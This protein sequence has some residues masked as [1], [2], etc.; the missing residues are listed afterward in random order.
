MIQNYVHLE[1]KLHQY[2][3]IDHTKQYTS[4]SKVLDSI[5]LKEDWNS[6][7]GK[8]AGYG[9]F[10]GMSKLDVLKLWDDNKNKSLSH[11]T[12]IHE[13]LERY[14]KEFKILPQ[15]NHLEEMIKG[16][17]EGYK[18]YYRSYD[19]VCLYSEKYLVAGTSD[20][21]LQRKKGNKSICIADYKTS[22]SKGKITY[23]NK[24]GKYL[25]GPVA[26]LQDCSYVRYCLQES[27]YGILYEELTGGTIE[28]MWVTFIPSD[29]PK[30]FFKI[31]AVYMRTDAINILEF[32]KQKQDEKI[33]YSQYK[34]LEDGM[35]DVPMFD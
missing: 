14:S 5:T 29:S 24:D 21:I 12:N 23:S 27:I 8:I 22:L 2:W 18:E 10:K 30:D 11:G 35:V 13:S 26:H 31:P 4:V 32:F 28:E 9:K 1:P 34:I 6:I 19:E 17:H 3:N 33:K 25:L 7:A 20:K 16:I 15:D